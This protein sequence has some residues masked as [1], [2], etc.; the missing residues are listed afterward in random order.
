[1]IDAGFDMRRVTES[2][3]VGDFNRDWERYYT[4]A[5]LHD[6]GAEGLTLSVTADLWNGDDND[7]SS[8]GADVSYAEDRWRASVGSYYSLYKYELL[9]LAERDDVRTYYLHAN[10][11]VSER[12]AL[13]FSHEPQNDDPRRLP[14]LLRLGA[15]GDSE[16]GR[17]PRARSPSWALALL[18]LAG[19]VLVNALVQGDASLP[20]ATSCT[21]RDR[22]SRRRLP[23]PLGGPDDPG[24]PLPAQC[25]LCHAQIDADKPPELKVASLFEGTR[26][27][28]ARAGHQSDVILY[29]HQR[30]AA[31]GL[32]C[33]ACHASVAEDEGH[34]AE[35][36]AKL[37]MSMEACLACHA[38]SAGP[39]ESECSSCHAEIRLDQ[40]PPSHRANWTR[41]HGT[42]VRGRASDR[43]DQ[44]ALCHQPSEC[45]N[46]HQIEPPEN[47]NNYWRRRGHGL[48]AS[49]DRDSCMT[50]HDSD[51]CQR[52]HGGPAAAQPRRRGVRRRDRHRLACYRAAARE[53]RG[54]CRPTPSHEQATPLPPTTHRA[55]TAASATATASRCRTS[56]TGRPARPATAEGR[57]GRAP[58]EA[59][60]GL[61]SPK[62]ETSFEPEGSPVMRSSRG[63]RS[64]PHVSRAA[65]H[66]RPRLRTSSYGG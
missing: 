5:T 37:R 43:A 59:G 7:T 20:S 39:K 22:A 46:C 9:E 12:L 24:M 19:C 36:G 27:K 50:C 14:N 40:P 26:F 45:T 15:H 33:A 62:A 52:C 11:K 34:L 3:N 56:T 21:W 47:H 8:L 66:R 10:K 1:V 23:R 30:H 55:W 44:C 53:S 57:E 61:P 4:T 65:A 2:G 60:E 38:S 31:R 29:S 41:Y 48:T 25:A 42:L 35:H 17:S 54:V 28:A 16:D 18:A 63:V 6:L 32:D 13:E 64:A 58:R 49:M 51:S